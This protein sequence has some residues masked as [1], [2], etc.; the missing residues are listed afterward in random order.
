[1]TEFEKA[2]LW[3]DKFEI[4]YKVIDGVINLPTPAGFVQVGDNDVK[5]FAWRC[6][7][8]KLENKS[9]K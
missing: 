8:E 1:M 2:I 7:C 5:Y 3:L 4:R 6:D 9:D